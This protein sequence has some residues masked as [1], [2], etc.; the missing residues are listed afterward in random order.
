[1]LIGSSPLSLRPAF[2][3]FRFGSPVS[4]FPQLGA[5]AAAVYAGR[6]PHV[7]RGESLLS[8]AFLVIAET[9]H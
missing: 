3:A 5:L 7:G 2:K 9:A 4:S 8:P 1:M 6:V